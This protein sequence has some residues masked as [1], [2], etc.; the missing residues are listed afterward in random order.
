MVFYCIVWY[1]IVLYGIVLYGTVFVL[2][3]FVL[4]CLV[5]S[6]SEK[7]C[8]GAVAPYEADAQLALLA[9]TGIIL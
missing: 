8:E 5:F 1:F 7:L 9:L 4:Y 6:I 2:Y 3:C